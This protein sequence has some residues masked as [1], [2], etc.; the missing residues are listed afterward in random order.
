[1]NVLYDRRI[2][3]YEVDA[4]QILIMTSDFLVASHKNEDDPLTHHTIVDQPS[5]ESRERTVSDKRD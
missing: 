5:V 2:R 1:M 4:M 3:Q